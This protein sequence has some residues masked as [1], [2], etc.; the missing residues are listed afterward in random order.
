ME[1]V[2]SEAASLAGHLRLG[3]LIY[4]YDD[5]RITIEGSTEPGLH[6]GRLRSGSRLTDGTCRR[7]DGDDL[8]GIE[9]A[10]RSSGGEYRTGLP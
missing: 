4:L 5:N 3:N 1:G 7:S 9:E 10:I 8:E 2:A 6:R